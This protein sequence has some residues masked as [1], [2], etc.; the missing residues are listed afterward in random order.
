MLPLT[1]FLSGEAGLGKSFLQINVINDS[2]NPSTLVTIHQT[3]TN[4]V[5]TYWYSLQPN[6]W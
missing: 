6:L 3:T 4:N 2:D 5:G 1:I